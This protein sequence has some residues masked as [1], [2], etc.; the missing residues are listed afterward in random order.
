MEKGMKILYLSYERGLEL[1]Q[2]GHLV[3]Y[4]DAF[5]LGDEQLS[6][7]TPALQ[8]IKNFS[9]EL[10]IERE[11]NDG[12]A[13]YSKF[14][15][16]AKKNLPDAKRAWW[17]IDTHV[18]YERHKEYA[19]NFDA[20][21]YA[22]SKYAKELGGYWLPLAYPGRSDSIR[23]NYG[24]IAFDISFV[25]RWNPQWFPKRTALI[26]GLRE[27][28]GNRFYAVTDYNNAMT[29]LRQSKVS[30]NHS[31]NDDMNFR[32][33]EILASGA[34]LVTDD[35]PDLYKIEGL[36]ERISIYFN[37]ATAP[38]YIDGIL[39]N[40]PLFTHNSLQNQVWVKMHHCLVHRHMAMLKML[41]TGVQ[42]EF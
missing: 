41:E 31:I 36:V 20:V 17:A 35:V 11:F 27:R 26:N 13:V 29:I 24:S 14:Y 32:V 8:Y 40:S 16:W 25:G 12:K 7:E 2:N 21:F 9:P 37:I 38:V 4:Q 23:R 18:S 3:M 19:K 42:L 34:E 6:T 15:A 28:Y 39:Q 1:E 33:W 30:V 5:T 22:I 10:I